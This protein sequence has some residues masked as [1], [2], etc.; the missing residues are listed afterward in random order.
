M[1]GRVLPPPT[2]DDLV[3]RVLRRGQPDLA[4]IAADAAPLHPQL[5][6]IHWTDLRFRTPPPGQT[7]ES[8]WLSMVLARRA[9]SRPLAFL[10]DHAG[11]PLRLSE[12]PSIH[13]SLRR[14]DSAMKQLTDSVRASAV[15]LYGPL[16]EEAIASSQ[17]EGANTTLQVARQLLRSGRQ[18]TDKGERMIVNNL[19]ALQW[20]K[21]HATAGVPLTLGMLLEL[22]AIV[23]KGTLRDPADAGRVQLPGEDRV[24]VVDKGRG[25]IVYE[26]PPAEDLPDRLDA[27]IGFANAAPDEDDLHP[28]LRAILLHFA[29]AYAHPFVDGNGR[30]ARALFFW[31]MLRAGYGLIEYLPISRVLLDAP[32]K[33]ARA[34]EHVETDHG[35]VTYFVVHHLD[36]LERSIAL[37]RE[38]QL[39][40]R[41]APEI[42]GLNPRQT[43]VLTEARRDPALAISVEAH[44]R[45][46]D[47]AYA[48]ARTDLLDLEERGFLAKQKRG[49]KFVFRPADDLEERLG[50]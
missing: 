21:P 38:Q 14:F 10:P 7:I 31:S 32:G 48:T 44:Q 39:N 11:E 47:V 49:R 13:H 3:A 33:Y 23:T 15:H 35:D 18:P 27:L 46:H 22:H 26:P 29:L 43:V 19:A 34:Y 12:I 36:V 8:W 30:V 45:M 25:E 42:E 6:Y 50:G 17:L 37:A 40:W 5:G 1:A 16:F 9:A 41:A 4:E 2:F 24:V 28:A 20:M